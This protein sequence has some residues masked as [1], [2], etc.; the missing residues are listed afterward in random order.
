MSNSQS[1]FLNNMYASVCGL[2]SALSGAA[3][4]DRIEDILMGFLIG[5]AGAAGGYL[6]K[7]LGQK[8]Q[9]RYRTWKESKIRKKVR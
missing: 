9:K 6:M 5:A 1:T 8:I 2:I 4:M 3:I 7:L